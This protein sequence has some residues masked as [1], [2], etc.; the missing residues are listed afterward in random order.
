MSTS[1][2]EHELHELEAF[3]EAEAE[4]AHELGLHEYEQEHEHEAL[5]QEQ[6]AE[7]FFGKLAS[8]A[9][10]AI[11]SPALRKIGLKAARA[12]VSGLGD[13]LFG[14]EKF[15]EHEFEGEGEA[16]EHEGELSP[17]RRVYPDA[18]LEHMAHM[19]SMAET[20]HE[21]A[22]LMLPVVPTIAAELAPL[23]M[24]AG[25][26]R[27]H[28]RPAAAAVRP[29]AA[30]PSPAHRAAPTA[31]HRPPVAPRSQVGHRAYAG[32]MRAAPALTRGVANITRTLHRNPI[33]RPLVRVIPTIARRTAAQ[34]ARTAAHGYRVT[35]RRAVRILA[36]QTARTLCKPGQCVHAY[37]RG[38]R[39]D[40][41]LHRTH[42][43]IIRRAPRRW[44][45]YP[46]GA[47]R[48][49]GT[50]GSVAAPQ[51]VATAPGVVPSPVAP[52]S[53][54]GVPGGAAPTQ[55]PAAPAWTGQP[56]VCTCVCRCPRC[57]G[58]R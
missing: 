46:I 56:Q 34:I 15:G 21:A 10:R 57:G 31:H 24:M 18:M 53:Y 6:E 19:A 51:P 22:E 7:Q 50:G 32:V 52:P 23:E 17:L 44:T 42:P 3:G 28:A 11:R 16:H 49:Y 37:R 13:V 26:S 38:R 39:L 35:P 9:S 27:P 41:Q 58:H 48:Y 36:Q 14:E 20:E 43:Q 54:A 2:Y 1:T 33:T 5:V 25:P 12:A 29:A 47:R 30:R 8:L 4:L 45:G 55:A 40:R